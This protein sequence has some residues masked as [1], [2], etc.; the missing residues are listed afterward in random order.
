MYFKIGL[1][2]PNVSMYF[3]ISISLFTHISLCV[4]ASLCL[5]LFTCKYIYIFVSYWV[6]IK[7]VKPNFVQNYVQKSNS[8]SL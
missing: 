1:M 4:F 7:K 2:L 8:V 5:D 6:I 3:K